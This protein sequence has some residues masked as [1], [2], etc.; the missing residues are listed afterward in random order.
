MKLSVALASP[1]AVTVRVEQRVR[2]NGRISW[3]TRA[4]RVVDVDAGRVRIDLGRRL[5]G[6]TLAPG[7][8]RVTLAT[9]ANAVA[10]RFSVARR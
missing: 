6:V 7:A 9:S 8:W 3:R 10:A 5:S 2:R 4:R 1:A